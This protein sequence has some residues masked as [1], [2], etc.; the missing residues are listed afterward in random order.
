MLLAY[1]V[2]VNLVT[3]Y[4]TDGAGRFTSG[5]SDRS[6]DAGRS[7]GRRTSAGSRGAASAARGASAKGKGAL[8]M[9]CSTS[10]GAGSITRGVTGVARTSLFRVRPIRPCASSSLS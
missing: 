8:I 4:K 5:G 7:K 1:V 10:K 2:T 6:A 9:C 3:K